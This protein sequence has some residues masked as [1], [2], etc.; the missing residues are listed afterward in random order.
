M[1]IYVY[2]SVC[3]CVCVSVEVEFQQL[4]ATVWVLG[5][6]LESSAGREHVLDP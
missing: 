4:W 1:F 2:V 5:T 6:E 3:G